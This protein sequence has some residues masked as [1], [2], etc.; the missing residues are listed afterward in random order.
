MDSGLIEPV[1]L[2]HQAPVLAR[3]W[4]LD[5]FNLLLLQFNALMAKRL[6]LN[7]LWCQQNVNKT[8]YD[9]NYGNKWEK[10]VQASDIPG[11]GVSIKQ[12]VIQNGEKNQIICRKSLFRLTLSLEC[13]GKAH[14]FILHWAKL[15]R[16]FGLSELVHFGPSNDL[17][18]SE[19]TIPSGFNSST[20]L[21]FA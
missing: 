10:L 6:F 12:N 1:N 7:W 16:N 21:E 17:L 9:F 3:R 4:S 15:W 5:V 11:I 20:G 14:V 2:A 18:A 8:Y 19:S 13:N